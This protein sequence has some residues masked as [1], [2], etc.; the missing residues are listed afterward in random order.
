MERNEAGPDD[1]VF[2]M[3]RVKLPLPAQ[4]SADKDIVSATKR[5]GADRFGDCC[6]EVSIEHN[7]L[8]VV[9]AMKAGRDEAKRTLI[10]NMLP[11]LC[12]VLRIPERDDVVVQAGGSVLRV[13]LHDDD[14]GV[15]A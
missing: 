9:C 8:L 13:D 3:Y 15:E 5:W 12:S 2:N 1:T 6:G 10:L 7:M 11:Q 14:D 4:R